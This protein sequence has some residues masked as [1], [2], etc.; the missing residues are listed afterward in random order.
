MRSPPR[1]SA[2]P[3]S[4]RP[5]SATGRP[6]SPSESA[7]PRTK[8]PEMSEQDNTQV[9]RAMFEAFGKGDVP[10]VLGMLTEDIEWRLAGPTEV[11]YAG[12]R[13]GRD[14]VAQFFK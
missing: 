9:V 14:Q 5:R 10:G 6:S 8:E 3:C 12:I 2:T 7:L 4:T 1:P 13:H 11:T